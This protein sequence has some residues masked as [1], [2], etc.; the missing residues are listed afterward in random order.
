MI[1][2]LVMTSVVTL[3]LYAV[4]CG[5]DSSSQPPPN[6]PNNPPP[7]MTGGPPPP[8]T[9]G[10][11]PPPNTGAPPPGTGAPPP[12][13]GGWPPPG[14]GAPSGPMATP[15]DPNV[16]AAATTLLGTV[17]ASQAPGM[18]KDGPG[19]AGQF[20]EG[21]V[22]EGQFQFVPGKCYTLVAAGVGIQQLDVEMFYTTPIPGLNPSIGRGTPSGA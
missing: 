11:A 18:Q 3:A 17:A 6:N 10:G 19:V 1:R 9:M 20:A 21:Q 8:N 13:G 16:A 4:G 7:G 5:G 14:G 15:V 12:T 2:P 22:L